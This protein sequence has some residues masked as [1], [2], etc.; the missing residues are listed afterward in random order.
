MATARTDSG[1]E[2]DPLAIDATEARFWR[3]VWASVPEPAAA[4]HGIESAEFGP[5]QMTVVRELGD[6]EM[7]NL[8]L[9]ATAPGAVAGGHL[10][11]AL[12]WAG[13]RGI[14][15]SVQVPPGEPGTEAAETALR[16]AGFAPGYG[17]M[18]FVRDVHPPRFSAAEEVE[19]VA[20]TAPDQEPFGAIVAAA[21]GLPAWGA[22]LFANLPGRAGW[23]CY[24]AKLD[25]AAQAAAAMFLEGEVAELGMGA[26]LEPARGRGAQ[27]ALLHRR[28]A[29]A[30]AAGA[31]LLFVETGERVPGRPSNSYRN[32]LRA[33]FEEAYVCPNWAASDRPLD[34]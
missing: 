15:L 22:E 16:T 8:L 20:L 23:H 10:P 19:V 2:Y 7:I 28:I 31:R 12:E 14:A 27:L 21:F 32:V 4:Q 33:G 5:V 9:G 24:V 18:R 25:G 3:D 1:V 17:W 11:T 26:T 13:E 30:P 6:A 29:D 34:G